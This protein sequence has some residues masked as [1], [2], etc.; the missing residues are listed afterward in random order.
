MKLAISK[1]L[2]DTNR[3]EWISM[4]SDF[5]IKNVVEPLNMMDNVNFTNVIRQLPFSKFEYLTQKCW[6]E[7]D[8]MPSSDPDKYEDAYEETLPIVL[9]LEKTLS[10]RIQTE[11]DMEQKNRISKQLSLV[12]LILSPHRFEGLASEINNKRRN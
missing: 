8:K 12:N 3:D 10:V 9:L 7:Q 2:N 1:L 5:F 6:E 11:R 4:K